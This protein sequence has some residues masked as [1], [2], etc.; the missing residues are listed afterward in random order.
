MYEMYVV[1]KKISA[2]SRPYLNISVRY[3]I[4][5]FPYGVF[6]FFFRQAPELRRAQKQLTGE[7]RNWSLPEREQK[8]CLTRKGF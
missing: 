7:K 8:M 6:L 3:K 4:A 1:K 5:S 2:I